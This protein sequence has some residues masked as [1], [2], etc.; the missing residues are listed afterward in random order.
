[1]APNRHLKLSLE[2]KSRATQIIGKLEKTRSIVKVFIPLEIYNLK[3]TFETKKSFTFF[4]AISTLVIGEFFVFSAEE[5]QLS[6]KKG[7]FT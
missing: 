5:F 7:T 3:T 4:R 2:D 1:M 6:S